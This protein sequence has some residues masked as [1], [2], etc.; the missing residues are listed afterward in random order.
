MFEK[1]L[2]DLDVFLFGSRS[3]AAR[4]STPSFSPKEKIT[5][6]EDTDYDFSLAFSLAT[7]STLISRGFSVVDSP[8]RDNLTS[9][10]LVKRYKPAFSMA[11]L[12]AWCDDE[13]TTVHIVMH[14]DE[15]LFRKVWKC[16]DPHFYYLA[17]WKR[18]PNLSQL[19]KRDATPL[20]TETMNQLYALKGV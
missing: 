2:A 3:M 4:P 7:A 1:D 6:Y 10:I 18:G 11:N 13:I 14:S 8:Y 15:E 5:L 16:I 9:A 17:L 20:I 19:S 12:R